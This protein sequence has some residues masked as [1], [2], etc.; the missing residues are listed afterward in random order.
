[1]NGTVLLT[2]TVAAPEDVGGGRAPRPGLR[3][4]WHEGRQPPAHG[5]AAAG[6]SAGPVRRGQPLAGRSRSASTC[7]QPRPRPA[8]SCSASARARR[9]R[10][11][12]PIRR[13]LAASTVSSAST[14]RRR[15]RSAPPASCSASTSLGALDLAESDGLVT[16]LAEPNLTALSGETASFLA[17]GEF[18]IP[19]RQAL[20]TVTIEYKQYGVGLAFTPTVLADGRISMRVRP[21]V[22]RAV[23]RGRGHAQRL[24]GPGADHAPRRN[25]GRARLRPEL[26]DRRP[27]A[28]TRNTNNDRQGAGPRRPA[29]PRRA[30]PLD[31]LPAARRPSW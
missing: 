30:V 1:M 25:D 29:D 24:P 9:H 7:C 3:R 18:P 20:G 21:E 14:C 10:S 6:Q 2:G 5:D 15:P 8:A 26:H 19:I 12:P 31:Q 16:I 4:R 17:G 23:E 27:A 22:S 28:A 13:Q 11:R